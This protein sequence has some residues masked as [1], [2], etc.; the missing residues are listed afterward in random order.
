MYG[1][2]SAQ[3]KD[4]LE[5]MQ[6]LWLGRMDESTQRNCAFIGGTY[7]FVSSL[8]EKY[9]HTVTCQNW[10]YGEKFV[11]GYGRGTVLDDT[12]S[13]CYTPQGEP[14][15]SVATGGLASDI[16]GKKNDGQHVINIGKSCSEKHHLLCVQD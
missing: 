14:V 9:S 16:E 12:F 1:Y 2:Y 13:I 8:S 11:S 3:I 10:T 4:F 5:K 7:S 6:D 15:Y